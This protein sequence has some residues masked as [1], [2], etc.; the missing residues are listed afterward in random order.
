MRKAESSAQIDKIF[1]YINDH[2]GEYSPMS[3]MGK[4]FNYL[5]ARRSSMYVYLDSIEGIPDNNI[6]ERA[7]R[8]FA[9]GKKNWLF[10]QSEDGADASAFFY[11]LIQTAAVSSGLN[12]TDYLEAVC[13][14]AST[15]KRDA[16]YEKLLPW[17]IDLSVLNQPRMARLAA[18]PA[19][20]NTKPYSLTGGNGC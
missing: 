18:Q 3:A 15:C 17:N 11:S 14:L 6:A 10:I 1:D 5:L 19:R 13:T 7:I 4:A 20:N 8:P 12:V 2:V 16:D 9:P